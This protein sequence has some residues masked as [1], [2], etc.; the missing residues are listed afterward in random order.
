MFHEDFLNQNVTEF[1]QLIFHVTADHW[2]FVANGIFVLYVVTLG[3]F[4]NRR[5]SFH[6]LLS[7]TKRT[8][9]ESFTSQQQI[10]M[11]GIG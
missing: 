9:V 7:C 2:D 8:N 5:L 4:R 10:L 11:D 1:S 6:L 3:N